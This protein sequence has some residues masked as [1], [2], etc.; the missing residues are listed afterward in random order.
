MKTGDILVSGI[1]A[2]RG[3][4]GVVGEDCDGLVV[5]KEF[6]TLKVRDE[7]NGS[8]EP[9]YIVR[10]LRSAKMRAIMEGAI[11]GVSNRTRIESPAELLRLPIP[12]LPSLRVQQSVTQRV[13]DAF[14]AQDAATQAFEAIDNE[15]PI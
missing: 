7:L 4:I 6:F 10:L 1:D 3:A 2:V 12:P 5:S 11:T 8:V 14:A 15:L 9:Q 13:A